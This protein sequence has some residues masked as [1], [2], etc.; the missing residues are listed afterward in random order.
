MWSDP[1]AR[2]VRLA[3]RLDARNSDAIYE[4]L[5]SIP[6]PRPVVHVELSGATHCTSVFFTCLDDARSR[7]KQLGADLSITSGSDQVGDLLAPHGTGAL[8]NFVEV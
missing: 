7:L 1:T 8:F 5:A 6:E 3:G 4:E 2:T